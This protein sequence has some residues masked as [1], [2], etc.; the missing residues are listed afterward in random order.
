MLLDA[1][2]FLWIIV[3]NTHV[4]LLLSACIVAVGVKEGFIEVAVTFSGLFILLLCFNFLETETLARIFLAISV[5][6]GITFFI[7]IARD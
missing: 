1:L 2:E 3:K 5:G 7:W 6:L 4:W